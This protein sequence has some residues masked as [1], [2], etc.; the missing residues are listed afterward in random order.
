MLITQ[1][2]FHGTYYLLEASGR[3]IFNIFRKIY[4]ILIPKHQVLIQPVHPDVRLLNLDL[5]KGFEEKNLLNFVY[6]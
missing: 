1:I 6:F 2:N 3:F 4:G 5:C